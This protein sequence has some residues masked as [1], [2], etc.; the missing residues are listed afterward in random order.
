MSMWD[1][2]MAKYPL[3]TR[4]ETEGQVTLENL[5]RAVMCPSEEYVKEFF[6]AKARLERL[7]VPLKFMGLIYAPGE[8]KVLMQ[9]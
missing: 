4:Y 2:N 3:E 8:W 5:Q 6:N 1:A 7:R 9:V